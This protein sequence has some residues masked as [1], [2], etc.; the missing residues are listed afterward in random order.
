MCTHS[1]AGAG[2]DIRRKGSQSN[3]CETQSLQSLITCPQHHDFKLVVE[4]KV[5]PPET[6]HLYALTMQEK[7]AWMSDISQVRYNRSS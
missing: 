1:R 3:M 4:K 5:G 6:V 2:S 7:A